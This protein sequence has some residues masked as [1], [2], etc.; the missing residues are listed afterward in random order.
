MKT[1]AQLLNKKYDKELL[2][3]KEEKKAFSNISQLLSSYEIPVQAKSDHD[4]I[5][6]EVIYNSL[7]VKQRFEE[8]FFDTYVKMFDYWY[9][10]TYQERKK[11]MNV[12]IDRLK[13]ELTCFM[14]GEEAVYMP[15]FDERI[16]HLYATE[17]VLL[18]L[19]Q[20]HR[21]IREC[22]S[23]VREHLYGV[24]PFQ[25]GFSSTRVYAEG[26]DSY[27]LYH[28]RTH[29]LY[30][31]RN[32]TFTSQLSFDPS[33]EE[34]EDT[35]KQIAMHMLLDQEEEILNIVLA[36]NLVAEKTKKKLRKLQAK[37]LKKKNKT[38]KSNK[39]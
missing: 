13:E 32:D 29:R 30:L 4:V 22:A 36:S 38:E 31:Y 15:S 16:N 21:Y 12:D 5:R 7:L 19:K 24:L 23:E 11:Q 20:Y 35:L 39:E 34:E 2:S 17:I 3:Y 1:L 6:L 14:S 27:V 18:D 28:P 8:V 33:C 9:D 26:E 37:Q 10:L 25:H